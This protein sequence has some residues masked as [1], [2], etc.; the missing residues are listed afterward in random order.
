MNNQEK[1]KTIIFLGAII[2]LPAA[3]Q[4]IEMLKNESQNIME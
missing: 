4:I 3:T 1:K 2:R